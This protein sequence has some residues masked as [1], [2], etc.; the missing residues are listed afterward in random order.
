MSQPTRRTAREIAFQVLYHRSKLGITPYGE[1]L[2]IQSIESDKKQLAYC[3]YLIR[4]TWENLDQIDSIIEKYLIN[5]KQSR[6][7]DS[8]NALLRLSVCELLFEPDIDG[9]IILN[10]AIEICK[11]YVDEKATKMCNGVLHAVYQKLQ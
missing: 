3:N 8:L 6:L 4:Q 1:E 2:L 5:W 7:S 11:Q 9:K 10:E